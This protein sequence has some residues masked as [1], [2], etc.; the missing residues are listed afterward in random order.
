MRKRNE[1]YL[2]RRLQQ[3][4]DLAYQLGSI[5]AT[6]VEQ[7]LEHAPAN[8]TARTQL[9]VLE[10]KGYLV[11]REEGGRF[12]YTPV[13]P[14]PTAAKAAMERF[15]QTFVDGSAPLALTTLL[16]A[17][18]TDLSDQELDELEEI[19]RKTRTERQGK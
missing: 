4:M 15:L 12:L 5:A 19:I 18:E 11:H 9:R 16:S 10:E 3:I 2:S 6:D 17:K 1:P 7:M 8:S 13:R 14:K